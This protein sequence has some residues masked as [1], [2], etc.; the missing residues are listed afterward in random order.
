MAVTFE[1]DLYWQEQHSLNLTEL[2][3]SCRSIVNYAETN[4]RGLVKESDIPLIGDTYYSY[5]LLLYPLP[6]IHSLATAIRT[7][8]R[9]IQPNTNNWWIKCWANIYTEQAHY[10][11]HQHHSNYTDAEQTCPSYHGIFCVQGNNSV[12]SYRNSATNATVHIPQHNNQMVII[13]NHP[14]W[15]HRTWPH[16]HTEDRITVAFNILH[17]DSIDAFRYPNHWMPL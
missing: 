16:K 1:R 4:F 2:E 12:T 10:D 5:N 15:H 14:D 3:Q 9:S 6:S 13:A 8:F 17:T 7:T 11:W